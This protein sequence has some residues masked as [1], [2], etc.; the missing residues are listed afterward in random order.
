[1]HPHVTDYQHKAEDAQNDVQDGKVVPCRMRGTMAGNMNHQAG[2]GC[3]KENDEQSP[4]DYKN[5]LHSVGGVRGYYIR[6][7]RTFN[8]QDG[9]QKH[10]TEA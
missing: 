2:Q 6:E 5:L 10:W 4:V 3:W 1:M 7:R 9:F 8:K